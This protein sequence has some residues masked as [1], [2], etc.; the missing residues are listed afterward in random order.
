MKT[1]S[2][3]SLIAALFISGLAAHS[4]TNVVNQ[5]SNI[6]PDFSKYT[7]GYMSGITSGQ[8][9][10]FL[11]NLNTTGR[12][13]D[14]WEL[15]FSIK[16]GAGLNSSHTVSRDFSDNFMLSGGIPSLFGQQD[17]GEIIFSFLDEGTG[18][19]LV[20]PFTGENLGFG[21]P[22]FP[23]L[24]LPLGIAPAVL[25]VLS[26]GVGY[27]TEVS[28]GLLPGVIKMAT[29]GLVEGLSV[30]NDL[31]ASFGARH[32]VFYWLPSLNEKNFSL[33]I[34]AQYSLLNL[35][36]AITPDLIGSL[37]VPSSDKFEVDNNLSGFQYRSSSLGFDALMTKKLAFLDLS[38]FASYNINQYKL[39]SLGSLDIKI[40]KSF[41]DSIEEG[42]DLYRLD[43]LIDVDKQ[44]QKFIFGL[45]MQFNLG[46][47]NLALKAAPFSGPY[48]S[49]GLGFKILKNKG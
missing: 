22:L 36:A 47:F 49:V 20:N 45:A 32:D 46:R 26:L 43:N 11:N 28:L 27:G 30:N 16:T 24:G 15:N 37:S 10:A 14:Q 25:P 41:Y 42:Y 17:A 29:N 38:L 33:T 40:T 39:N 21:L 4:Q 9:F 44:L 19:P 6:S 48:Y 3:I 5:I 7:D 8:G 18:L 23:G 13:L 1:K 2:I 31:I 12:L 34:G 35:G